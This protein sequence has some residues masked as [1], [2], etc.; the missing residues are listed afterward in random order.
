MD[1]I[2]FSNNDPNKLEWDE[3]V[4]SAILFALYSW[5]T[6]LYNNRK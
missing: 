1:S 5:V 2:K 3:I 6:N 4:F